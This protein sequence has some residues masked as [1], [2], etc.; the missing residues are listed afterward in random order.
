MG[1]RREDMT[2][3]SHPLWKERPPEDSAWRPRS[4]MT[5]TDHIAEQDKSAGGRASRE[6]RLP[7]GKLAR[8][9]IALRTFQSGRRIY[10]YLRWADGGKTHERYVGEVDEVSREANL[11]AAWRL[12]HDLGLLDQSESDVES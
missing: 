2:S 8:A 11:V 1:A 7:D 5:R 3:E 10:A 6:V 4:G 9:S 12:A